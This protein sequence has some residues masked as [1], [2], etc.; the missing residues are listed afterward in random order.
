M[1]P[2]PYSHETARHDVTL[3][4]VTVVLPA[5][6]EEENLPLVLEG[7]PEIVGE[8]VVVDG[9]SVDDTV[10]VA[11]E[12]RPD[13]R[14]VRQT[15]SGKGNALACGFAAATGDIVITLNADGSTD[16]GEIPR[17]VDALLAGA[18]VAH[19][20]RFRD[21]GGDYEGDRLV[22]IGNRILNWLVNMLFGTRFTDL[23][24]GYNAFW[25]SLVPALGLPDT[26]RARRTVWG[27]G[28]E[29]EPLI[30]IRMATRGLRVVEVASIGYPRIHGQREQHRLRECLR[31][32]RTVA[33]EYVDRWRIARAATKKTTTGP[34][35]HSRPATPPG[36]D[37][38]G[39][40]TRA[41]RAAQ[42]A[43]ELLREPGRQGTPYQ[44]PDP[45]VDPYPSGAFPAAAP[46]ARHSGAERAPGPDPATPDPAGPDPTGSDPERPDD[47][48]PYAADPD[49]AG[50]G[51]AGN[52]WAGGSYD[53]EDTA[54]R[55]RAV[56]GNPVPPPADRTGPDQAWR[57]GQAPWEMGGRPDLTVIR[58]ERSHHTPPTGIVGPRRPGH[59]RAV[60]GD[61]PGPQGT[62]G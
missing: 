6:N 49:A 43:R 13:A 37:T 50:L 28:A 26:Q 32:L 61:R 40:R 10:A 44:G 58:G 31:A 25:R 4:S 8:V 38:R 33:A 21:G 22:R 5:L 11:R 15:R 27:D 2:S 57:T 1:P 45:R 7:L 35:R 56:P 14:I 41:G 46:G 20:S 60:S 52:R 17:Y 51:P 62:W 59:L 24:F 9:G 16:P 54:A 18:E 42:H 29:I 47:A 53:D 19:G 36:E 48:G 3:P 12:V 30:N 23:G 34:A 55:H 39:N